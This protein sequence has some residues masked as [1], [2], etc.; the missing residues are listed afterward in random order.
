VLECH[1]IDHGEGGMI[2]QLREVVYAELRL[3]GPVAAKGTGSA[4][5]AE[6]VRDALRNL[7]R[8]TVLERSYLDPDS[9]HEI[10][11]EQ[12]NLSRSAYFRRLR[13]AADR[14]AGWLLENRQRL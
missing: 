10:V 4:A 8:R 5:S 13:Q 1:V 7:H 14:L 12:L 9:K 3:P 6:D 11:A 2:G